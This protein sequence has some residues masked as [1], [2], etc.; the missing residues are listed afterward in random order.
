VLLDTGADVSAVKSLSGVAHR[1][2]AV[3]EV[4]ERGLPDAFV[5]ASAD[6]APTPFE[7]W[8]EV[9]VDILGHKFKEILGV[10]A[11][12]DVDCILGQ[13]PTLRCF[14][15]EPNLLVKHPF[16]GYADDPEE[17]LEA[18]VSSPLSDP[19]TAA[20]V[21]V[22]I[23]PGVQQLLEANKLCK[24]VMNVPGA[25]LK[26]EFAGEPP[27]SLISPQYRLSP[28]AQAAVDAQVDAWEAEGVI[29]EVKQGHYRLPL[30]AAPKLSGG[31]TPDGL[32]VCL[33]TRSLNARLRSDA[34]EVPLTTEVLRKIGNA[35]LFSQLDLRAAFNQ[36]PV[37][38][39]SQCFL[40]FGNR[41]R[42][43]NYVRSPFGVKTLSSVFQ[44]WM[45]VLLAGLEDWVLVYIDNVII[46]TTDAEV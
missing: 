17:D 19:V 42:L 14:L 13:E 33:D 23:P 9:E 22:P 41:G 35:Q 16:S 27:A 3:A 12:L 25:E 10:V 38:P 34:G 32:R 44:F 7:S 37:H 11:S 28:V 5:Q 43:F 6:A 20:G 40:A 24:G 8:V 15:L 29:V 26:L 46:Y 31:A 2:L 30:L 21:P 4:A 39:D 36:L 45:N 1:V 18:F